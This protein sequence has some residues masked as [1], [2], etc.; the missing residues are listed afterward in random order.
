MATS[1]HEDRVI[2]TATS[3]SSAA[4]SK[5]AA[6]WR[7]SLVNH[8]LQP[9]G[10]RAADSLGEAEL[11]A[12]RE[13]AG[14]LLEIAAPVMDRVFRSV[15]GAGCCVLLTNAEGVILDRRGTA[16]DENTFRKW[17]LWPGADW[18]EEA[19]G[20]NGIGTCLVE[21]RAVT[22]HREQHFFTRN[23]AMSCMDAPIFDHNGRLLAAL[24]VSSCRDDHTEAMAALIGALVADAARRIEADYFRSVFADARILVAPQ[25]GAGEP[26]LF[27][28]DRD[29][30]VVGATRAARKAYGLT[31]ATFASPRPADDLFATQRSG[32]L[33]S[34]ERA[35][36]R[37]AIAS[38]GGNAA[39]AA[40]QLG[41]SRATLYRRMKRLGAE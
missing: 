41:I 21:E 24:D 18:S 31:D 34:A 5:I 6:S 3:D 30:L 10:V 9:E 19:E 20:T 28:V 32:D 23:T 7:R 12:A 16:A 13:A 27:A 29:D 25:Q 35:A 26:S 4:R 14:N 37:R 40:R 22:I 1:T 15:D 2:E 8:G 33:A 17:G 38:T 39:A 36:I 11:N